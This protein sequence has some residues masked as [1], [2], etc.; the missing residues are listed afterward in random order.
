MG[1]NMANKKSPLVIESMENKEEIIKADLVEEISKEIEKDIP[2]SFIKIDLVSNG[3]ILGIPKRLH[4]RD[5]SGSDAIDINPI[6]S[7]D[8]A[9]AIGKVLQRMCYENFDIS[10]LPV[11]DV[12]YILMILQ[13][14]FINSVIERKFY[15]NEELESGKEEGQKDHPSNIETCEIPIS[16]IKVAFLGKDFDD[17]DISKEV[18]FPFTLTDKQT[19]DKIKIKSPTL[20]DS[21]LAQNYCKEYFKD[22]HLEFFDVKKKINS[23]QSI[24]DDIIR[25][26]KLED[27]LIENEEGC[28]AYYSF[29][30]EYEMMI[31]QIIQALQIVEYNGKELESLNEQWDVYCN[32]VSNNIWN[33]Y[34]N[35]LEKY[36]FGL[37]D[38]VEVYSNAKETSITRGL[39]FQF[40]D[41]LQF[42][43]T[44]E[45]GRFDISFD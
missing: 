14:T 5:F 16:K 42:N 33:E 23:L 19:G 10:L 21:V 25:Q 18:K 1:E 36:P 12:L 15:I 9:K 22:R 43:R 31:A 40:D 7:E 45:L 29:V 41:F 4:F 2:T 20:K 39:G 32:K 6:D 28:K 11:Q 38:T 8:K 34:A 17:N 3:R 26:S 35:I 44:K 30:A 13:A 24:K 37:K 27:Y